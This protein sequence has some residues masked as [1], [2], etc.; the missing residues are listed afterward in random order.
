MGQDCPPVT[1]KSAA[2]QKVTLSPAGGKCLAGGKGPAGG[3]S[4]DNLQEPEEMIEAPHPISFNQR[5]RGR[6]CETQH[7]EIS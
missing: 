6:E 1:S 4:Y 7:M 3:K 2:A 5:G